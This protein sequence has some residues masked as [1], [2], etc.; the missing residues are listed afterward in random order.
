MSKIASVNPSTYQDALER[1]QKIARQLQS[2]IIAH[3]NAL[4][5]N[6]DSPFGGYKKSGNSRTNGIEGFHEITRGKLV[7]EE[8]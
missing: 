8:K 7:S 6:P 4:Y 2:G 5:Y 3:N 1:Y